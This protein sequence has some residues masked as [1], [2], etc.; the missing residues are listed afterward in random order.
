MVEVPVNYHNLFYGRTVP[1]EGVSC[2]YR[3][4]IDETEALTHQARLVFVGRLLVFPR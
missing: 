1:R 3:N 4:M 2:A